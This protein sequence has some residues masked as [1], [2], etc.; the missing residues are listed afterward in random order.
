MPAAETLAASERRGQYMAVSP[1]EA[2][3][4]AVEP[5]VRHVLTLSVRN[6]TSRSRRV[7]ITPPRHAAFSTRSKGEVELAA[8]LELRV[9]LVYLSDQREDLSDKMRISVHG[10]ANGEREDIEIPVLAQ[11]PRGDVSLSASL[12]DFGEVVHSN[13][14]SRPLTIA[15]AGAADA[16][17]HFEVPRE[18]EHSFAI[19]PTA[20]V[21]P[22]RGKASVKVEC[23]ASKL[24][25]EAAA[26]RVE[27]KGGA[28]P[29]E[30]HFRANVVQQQLVVTSADGAPC[31]GV[32]FGRLYYGL[33]RRQRLR[34][35]NT[36]PQPIDFAGSLADEGHEG[37]LLQALRIEPAIGMLPPHGSCEVE[38]VFAPSKAMNQSAKG[39][40]SSAAEVGERDG[41]DALS[42]RYNFESVE[43]GQKV[44]ISIGAEAIR[45]RVKLSRS[46]FV[47]GSCAQY[48]HLDMPLTLK[49][50]Q[51]EPFAFSIPAVANFAAI[52]AAGTVPAGGQ[53]DLLLR[54]APHQL[55]ALSIVLPIH[56]FG[57][58]VCSMPL[59]LSGTCTAP[60]ARKP[61]GGIDKLPE[62]FEALHKPNVVPP[63]TGRSRSPPWR[64]ALTWQ[65]TE[66]V[67]QFQT[68][69]G[70][71]RRSDSL[72]LDANLNELDR[73]DTGYE[74]SGDEHRRRLSHRSKY[75]QFLK[76]AR[77][78]R[79]A[80]RQFR[81]RGVDA[82]AL[83][84]GS[85]LGL[86][87]FSGLPP[88]F[89]EPPADPGPLYLQQPYV[90]ES[91]TSP[92]AK[93]AVFDAHKPTAH[94]FKP[95]PET[96]EEVRDCKQ[97]L[98]PSDLLLVTGGPK[99]I[100]F[101]TISV[102][103]TVSRSFSVA[104]DMRVGVLVAVAA[105]EEAE[106]EASSPRS[107]VIPAGAVAGFD[108][109][110]RC[111]H[112]TSF[113]R[114][115]TYTINGLH[116]FKFTAVAEVVPLELSLSSDELLF[117]FDDTSLEPTATRQIVLSNPGTHAAAFAWEHPKE[118]RGKP[119]FVPTPAEG[120]I[121]P[122]GRGEVHVAF[123]PFLGCNLE[124]ALTLIVTG[125]AASKTLLCR[126]EL[127]EAKVV[128]AEK[129]L[130]FGNIAVGVPNEKARAAPRCPEL[131]CIPP[132][133]VRT[134]DGS[135]TTSRRLLRARLFAPSDI[136]RAKMLD[137]RRRFRLHAGSNWPHT[138][139]QPPPSAHTSRTPR[140]PSS[141]AADPQPAQRG[142]VGRHLRLRAAAGRLGVPS[143]ARDDPPVVDARG[144]G[145]GDA[146]RG[147]VCRQP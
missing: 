139:P 49:N 81:H 138:S 126:A 15:N 46:G 1:A 79:E 112:P 54:F 8:G 103:T 4:T 21:V 109:T 107:Q 127:D 111:D 38:L 142:P 122:K 25:A 108:I 96:A 69:V 66:R 5:G 89:P 104:N 144:V 97:P 44:T 114:T 125:G 11:Q 88:P 58:A 41:V 82:E 24:G 131:P 106:L 73:M 134:R 129:R 80:D 91:S 140:T 53:V 34:L 123:S 23:R 52:P 121:P 143:D 124:H 116:A 16:T 92:R 19:A 39:F 99:T 32:D 71:I 64:H 85:D 68:S 47:F 31:E 55:G 141:P 60:R 74:L 43:L 2:T 29:A 128:P 33:E 37:S 30:V 120:V 105:D 70:L 17:V 78:E 50:A 135:I 101:G 136:A 27:V 102:R 94:K 84:F 133:P 95:R 130:P 119:A 62:D 115:V 113:K 26:A 6:V 87:P 61:F 63:P 98:S 9:E 132:P 72:A 35:V 3:F 42:V 18:A 118:L 48:E 90:S 7:R 36:G 147:D 45:P 28:G 117:Q 146:C 137:R 56:G 93:R 67:E 51:E 57:G 22:A 75:D 40:A 59:H 83:A 145:R 100:D 12:V 65:Q 110:F 86:D 20:V 77:A 14:I 10:D 13:P 76:T